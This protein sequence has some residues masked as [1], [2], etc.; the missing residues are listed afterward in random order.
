MLEARAALARAF[1]DSEV[2]EAHGLTL[3]LSVPIDRGTVGST[4]PVD[5]ADLFA[6]MEEVADVAHI[7]SFSLGAVSLE[8]VIAEILAPANAKPTRA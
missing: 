8:T 6:A 4:A 3:R 7:E 5:L 2:V 1:P